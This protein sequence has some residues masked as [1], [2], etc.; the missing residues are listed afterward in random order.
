ML[1]KHK[2]MQMTTTHLDICYNFE[3]RIIDLYFK[4]VFHKIEDS[5]TKTI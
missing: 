5:E 4:V 2:L 3:I 1:K